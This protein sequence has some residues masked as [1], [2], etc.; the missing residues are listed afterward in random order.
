MNIR[1]KSQP[2]FYKDFQTKKSKTLQKDT[3]TV[4]YEET[5]A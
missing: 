4:T 2:I 3:V 1:K 5:G